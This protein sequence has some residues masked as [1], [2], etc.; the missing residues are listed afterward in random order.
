MVV[1]LVNNIIAFLGFKHQKGEERRAWYE[2]E[3]KGGLRI[4]DGCYS[5][6]GNGV[7]F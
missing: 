1:Y 7:P 6:G 4:A 5:D 3:N 2:A